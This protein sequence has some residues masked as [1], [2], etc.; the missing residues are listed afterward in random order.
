MVSVWR[1]THSPP[2]E[3]TGVLWVLSGPTRVTLTPRQGGGGTTAPALTR[4]VALGGVV[5]HVVGSVSCGFVVKCCPV[6]ALLLQQGRLRCRSISA[7]LGTA[8]SWLCVC[9]VSKL[10]HL[11]LVRQILG[12]VNDSSIVLALSLV[13]LVSHVSENPR[14]LSLHLWTTPL[15]M[16]G[17]A[18]SQ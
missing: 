8:P 14:V 11:Q 4:V 1:A 16:P 3:G 18:C 12:R 2:R 10:I 13:S 7:E 9:Q 5:V 6:S 17:H 15:A